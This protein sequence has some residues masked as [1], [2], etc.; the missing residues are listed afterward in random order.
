M[1]L[2]YINIGVKK[3]IYK[4][5]PNI[6]YH[7]VPSYYKHPEFDTDTIDTKLS[8]D[9]QNKDDSMSKGRWNKLQS[10]EAHPK[11]LDKMLHTR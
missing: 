7:L 11:S 4:I 6:Y 3:Q 5:T 2:I 8:L 10:S 1:S 9:I